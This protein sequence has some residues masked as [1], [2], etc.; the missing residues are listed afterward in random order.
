MCLW[1]FNF[2]VLWDC[3]IVK[4]CSMPI[5]RLKN[6]FSLLVLRLKIFVLVI[7]LRVIGLGLDFKMDANSR[8]ELGILIDS[9]SVLKFEMIFRIWLF[10]WV[11]F[12]HNWVDFVVSYCV[13]EILSLVIVLWSWVWLGLFDWNGYGQIGFAEILQLLRPMILFFFFLFLKNFV[14]LI[15]LSLVD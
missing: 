1:N 2:F 10:I 9:G 11:G 4:I 3:S 5:L 7:W 6:C 12:L 15:F 8:L 13:F 14:L